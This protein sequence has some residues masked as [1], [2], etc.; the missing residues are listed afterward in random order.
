[1][2]QHPEWPNSAFD[3]QGNP[4]TFYDKPIAVLTGPGAVSNGDWESLRLGYHPMARV[5]GKPTCGAY[6]LNDWP[7]LGYDSWY[8]TRSTGSGYILPDHEY[9]AHRSATIDE[10]VWLTQ[11]DVANGDDTVV[12]TAME[13]INGISSYDQNKVNLPIRVTLE[14][15]YP[16]PFNPSTVIS[17]TLPTRRRQLTDDRVNSKM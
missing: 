4:F 1:M 5:F 2:V 7:D 3:I 10:E 16:N 6:T 12:K 9:M 15:N 14:Q 8:F 17:Y 13:W 11:E